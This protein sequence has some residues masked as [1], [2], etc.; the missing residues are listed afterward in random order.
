MALR[1]LF[2]SKMD[3]E[4]K[5]PDPVY[6]RLAGN[7]ATREQAIGTRQEA[8]RRR[9]NIIEEHKQDRPDKILKE[10]TRLSTPK[11]GL[12]LLPKGT[13]TTPSRASLEKDAALNVDNE[14]RKDIAKVAVWELDRY[15]PLVQALDR[16]EERGASQPPPLDVTAD[17]AG[18]R[19]AERT[20]ERLDARRALSQRHDREKA[21]SQS[22]SEQSYTKGD[23]EKTLTAIQQRRAEATGIKAI[24]YRVSGQANRDN[25]LEQKTRLTLA[26]VE[27]KTAE[28]DGA[29]AVKHQREVKQFDNR[30]AQ[31]EYHGAFYEVAQPSSAQ[32]QPDHEFTPEYMEAWNR[33]IA[34][35]G[36]L[37]AENQQGNDYEGEARQL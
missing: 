13:V 3:G 14:H 21:E 27:R 5:D 12:H 6:H 9:E 11:R 19:Q 37:A 26:G 36:T 8:D 16:L 18:I 20:L 29:L 10:I 35:K 22:E 34:E 24:T 2:T 4:V 23:L 15:R 28:R 17:R 1:D 7:A 31:T 32:V 25:E 30:L 33:I